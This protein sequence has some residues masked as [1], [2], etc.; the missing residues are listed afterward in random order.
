LFIVISGLIPLLEPEE[1]AWVT[2]EDDLLVCV[3]V[4]C[5]GGGLIEVEVEVEVWVCSDALA[6]TPAN[7]AMCSACEE[8]ICVS[9]DDDFVHCE[10]DDH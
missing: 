1:P 8:D 9:T 6:A 4:L 2:H 3:T 10:G 5:E 7:R